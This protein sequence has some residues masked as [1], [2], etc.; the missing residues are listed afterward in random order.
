VLERD[1]AQERVAACPCTGMQDSTDDAIQITDLD[2]EPAPAIPGRRLSYAKLARYRQPLWLVT[3]VA[4]LVLLFLLV[5]SPVLVARPPAPARINSASPMNLFSFV[6]PGRE[7][8]T[9]V[10]SQDGMLSALRQSTGKVLWRYKEAS[11]IWGTPWVSGG[12]ILANTN[13]GRVVAL[14]ATTGKPLWSHYEASFSTS[15]LQVDD[16][17]VFVRTQAARTSNG[18]VVALR[19]GD[20]SPV[21][22][23]GVFHFHQ[24]LIDARAGR[25][26]ISDGVAITALRTL[27]GRLLWTQHTSSRS[28]MNVSDGLVAVATQN[29]DIAVLHADTGF[30]YW[31]TR[32]HSGVLD[33]P[34][35]GEREILVPSADG[36]MSAF[37][38]S[39]GSWRWSAESEPLV[40]SAGLVYCLTIDGRMAV[41]RADTGKQLRVY[42]QITS[43]Q[44][45]EG[46]IFTVTKGD[47]VVLQAATG[48]I[49]WRW[50]APTPILTFTP[51]G[52]LVYIS[53]RTGMTALSA[54]NGS[55]R[56]DFTLQQ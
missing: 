20:G 52:T 56:W 8:A 53:T 7:G 27:S 34:L 16:S 35:I 18:R 37:D 51:T 4:G 49:L 22:E 55:M 47:L 40:S 48:N 13:D 30:Q 54:G 50:H 43:V 11:G 39:T 10:V 23:Q 31:H 29:G 17:L 46:K 36:G 25:T 12:I 38:I 1:F 19:A 6:V 24:F 5:L 45:S 26:Y 41:L 44:E 14:Q 3:A 2:S 15:V 21:W 28:W 42:Q 9:L 33:S 32:S